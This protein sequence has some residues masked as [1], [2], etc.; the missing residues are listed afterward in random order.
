MF[1][2]LGDRVLVKEIPHGTTDAGIYLPDDSKVGSTYDARVIALGEGIMLGSGEVLPHR[3]KV[4]DR[5]AIPHSVVV[6]EYVD[7]SATYLI[8]REQD[9]AGV[10]SS[11]ASTLEMN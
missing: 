9:I 5:V 7:A 11:V 2:P 10:Y 1:Q 3:V 8:V 6:L 4:G